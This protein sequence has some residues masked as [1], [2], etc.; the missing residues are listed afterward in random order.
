MLQKCTHSKVQLLHICYQIFGNTANYMEI[1]FVKDG[2]LKPE[3]R[4]VLKNTLPSID[5]N[6]V[7]WS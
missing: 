3:D 1:N 7:I 5:E 2:R 6:H 4:S